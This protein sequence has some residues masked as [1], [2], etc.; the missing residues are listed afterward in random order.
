MPNAVRL[1]FDEICHKRLHNSQI[2]VT[3]GFNGRMRRLVVEDITRS[4]GLLLRTK[5]VTRLIRMPAAKLQASSAVADPPTRNP[6][7]SARHLC[8]PFTPQQIRARQIHCRVILY[9]FE[10]I[11]LGKATVPAHHFGRSRQRADG[12]RCRYCKANP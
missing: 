7:D 11:A 5:P 3:V 9:G 8:P 6:V 10:L 1:C 4:S 2:G 12:L